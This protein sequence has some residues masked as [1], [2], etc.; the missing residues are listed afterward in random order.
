MNAVIE[1]DRDECDEC[2]HDAHVQACVYAKMPSGRSIAFC[3]HHGRENL[4]ALHE[5]GATVIDLSHT[6]HS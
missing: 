3:M 5:Q 6:A 1:V 2:P 4:I